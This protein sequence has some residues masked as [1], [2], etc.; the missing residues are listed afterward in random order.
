MDRKILDFNSQK[1]SA[2]ILVRILDGFWTFCGNYMDFR[3]DLYTF[4]NSMDFRIDFRQFMATTWILDG[5]LGVLP[6][7]HH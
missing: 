3:M 5:I 2:W 1:V 6:K 4:S 7:I